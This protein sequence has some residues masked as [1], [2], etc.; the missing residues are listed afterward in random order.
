MKQQ[1]AETRVV[2]SQSLESVNWCNRGLDGTDRVALS[3]RYADEWSNGSGQ[4]IAD[5]A[6]TIET[7][8]IPRLIQLHRA[9]PAVAP[10][11]PA[12]A[13]GSGPRF[14]TGDIAEFTRVVL[15]HDACVA[16]TFI[17]SLRAEG[18]ALEKL[19]LDLIAPAARRLG[20][21]WEDDLADF[22]EVTLAL[23]RLQQL[24]HRFSDDFLSE[25]VPPPRGQRILLTPVP[26]DQ[27][28]FGLIMVAEFFRRA[29]WNVMSRL[30][31][32]IGDLTGAV[33]EGW[34][35]IVGFSVNS[36]SR[37]AA[38]VSSIEA[39]RRASSNPSINVM[40]GG[41][42]FIAHPELVGRVGADATAK[43]GMDA[44]AHAE[45]LAAVQSLCIRACAETQDS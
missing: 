30:S 16:V 9:A 28:T 17:E 44:V 1:D 7:E 13:V 22:V 4:R 42:L 32:S 34:F 11:Y 12:G 3:D 6:H 33:R 40:V 20:E 29:G 5:L 38:L 41:P 31:P 10:I 18:Y 23:G 39:I 2:E 27:H 36:E 14:G 43:D 8:I 24:L 45:N 35:E 21:L 37:V 19:Y 15:S 26:G 25:A